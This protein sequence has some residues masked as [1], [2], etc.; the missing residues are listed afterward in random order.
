[1][2][3]SRT[4][5]R[6]FYK[7][8]LTFF[9]LP[10]HPYPWLPPCAF[11]QLQVYV[12]LYFGLAVGLYIARI[13][14]WP[15][16][17]FRRV[18]QAL[19]AS[20]VAALVADSGR[21]WDEEGL[22]FVTGTP[23]ALPRRL[24]NPLVAGL[25]D[26]QELLL[27][28]G[29]LSTFFLFAFLDR[30]LLLGVSRTLLATFVLAL[31]AELVGAIGGATVVAGAVHTHADGLLDSLD[32]DRGGRGRDPLMRLEGQSIFG[33]QGAGSLLLEST[34]VEFLRGSGSSSI[35]GCGCWC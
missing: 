16:A 8:T 35:S 26:S 23:D 1:M 20:D 10:P 22:A 31:V 2:A 19:C 32:V 33:E 18:S 30:G 34:T 29:L 17:Q 5:R 7:H 4:L 6:P 24:V 14:I 3:T 11:G 28:L 12:L 15:L 9:T 13:A 21:G 25:S 27:L